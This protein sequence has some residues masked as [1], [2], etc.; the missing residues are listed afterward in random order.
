NLAYA[1]LRQRR[2]DE[3]AGA[4]ILAVGLQHHLPMAH[5][6]LGCALVRL[7]LIDRAI[8]AF[9]MALNQRGPIYFAHRW[10]ARLYKDQPGREER[11]AYHATEAMKNGE[12]R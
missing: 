7:Q 10:L 1:L 9:Q 6:Y 12:R 8:Q 3:A 4:A 11:S 5:F 2:Y